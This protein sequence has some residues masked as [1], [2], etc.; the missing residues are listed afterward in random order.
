MKIIN[1]FPIRTYR[2]Q[3]LA[4]LYNPSLTPESASKSLAR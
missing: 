1:E 3:E 2:W 4:H